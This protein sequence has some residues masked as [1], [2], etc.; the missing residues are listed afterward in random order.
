[1]KHIKFHCKCFNECRNGGVKILSFLPYL[2]FKWSH[3]AGVRSR[4][5]VFGWLAWSVALGWTDDR[6]WDKKYQII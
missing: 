2:D 4:I 5:F 3:I 6:D 1:M